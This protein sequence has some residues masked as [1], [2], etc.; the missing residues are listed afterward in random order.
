MRD[1]YINLNELERK[2]Y[3]TNLHASDLADLYESLE[4]DEQGIIF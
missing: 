3:L 1:E 4:E 2:A